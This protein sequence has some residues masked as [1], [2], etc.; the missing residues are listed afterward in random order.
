MTLSQTT[1][2][3]KVG[4]SVNLTAEVLPIEATDRTVV[5]ISDNESVATVDGNGNVTAVALGTATITANCGNVFATCVVTVDPVLVESI[6][7]STTNWSGEE[8]EAFHI[9]ATVIPE[10]ATDKSLVWSSSDETVATVDSEGNVSVLKEG[11]CVITATAVD[12]SGVSAECI[13][14]STSG[15]AGIFSETENLDIYDFNGLLIKKDCGR[16]D[17][18]TLIPGIYIIRQ[19]STM[20]KL[21]IR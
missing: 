9:D 13:I 19:G 21:V 15:V 3:L 6:T 10:D 16:E 12:G 2:E 20:K 4:E 7:F 8:G 1:A 11:T 5:W 18:K 17:I 14:T